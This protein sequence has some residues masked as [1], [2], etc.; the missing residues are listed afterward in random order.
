MSLIRNV[1]VYDSTDTNAWEIDANNNGPVVLY[2]AAGNQLLNTAA[3]R[4]YVQL[5]DGTNEPDIEQAADD[6][7]DMEDKF[8]LVTNAILNGR[9]SNT[10]IRPLRI[11]S[12]THSIQTISYEHHE[13]H[14]GSSFT[15]SYQV[16]AANGANADILIVTPDSTKE[17]HF[18]YEVDVEAEAQLYIYEAPTATA[19]ANPIVAYNRNRTGT[20]DAATVVL[21]HTPTSITEGTT[22]IRSHHFGA[23]KSF[24]GGERSSHEFVLKLN[25]KYLFRLTNLTTGDNWF[26]IILNWYEHSPRD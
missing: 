1:K 24:G 7:S 21:T 8:G 5:T 3:T 6:S 11:D 20:P 13:I 19:A 25:T 17:A 22:V 12:S 4:G 23:G 26:N 14:S 9:I 10:A 15:A 2:D 18:F 16:E